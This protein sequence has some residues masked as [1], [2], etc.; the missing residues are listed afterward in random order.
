V[1][2]NDIIIVNL[3]NAMKYN[4]KIIIIGLTPQGLSLLRTLSREGVSVTAFYQNPKNVGVYS[5]YGDKIHF[6]DAKDLKE[7]IQRLVDDW[8][9][10]PLCY[11][12][13]GELL[14]LVLREYPELYQQC[15]VSSGPYE[16]VEM[17]AHKDRMYELAIQKGFTVAK[18][19]TLDKYKEDDFDYPLFMKRNY[20]IPLFF[21]AVKIENHETM[22]SYLSRI[23]EEEKKDIIVQQ[24]ID[25][26]KQNLIN[27]TGQSFYYQGV[28]KG[29]YV[30]SQVRRLKKGI[31]SYIEEIT[32]SVMVNRITRLMDTFMLELKYEGFAEFEFM[33]DKKKDVLFFIEI[34][35]RTCGLQNSLYHK[36]VNL[37]KVVL[38]PSKE[39]SLI[40]VDKP[41]KWMNIMRDVRSRIETRDFS[42]IGD[43]LRSKYDILDWHDIKPFIKQLL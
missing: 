24:W 36:F 42:H 15:H 12:T 4:N 9:Y 7:K 17:L 30:A 14:A 20:E 38:H 16:V 13:S 2:K 27:I 5:K 34:N 43:V 28:S 21:K 3:E 18:Y 1:V 11:I 41:L 22:F 26:S 19:V 29:H 39:E 33:Y 40:A 6:H 10:S 23:K 37:G 8:G 25:I 35:T 32:D 31:T